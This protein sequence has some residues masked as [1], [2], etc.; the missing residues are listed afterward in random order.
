[1]IILI[2]TRNSYTIFFVGPWKRKNL[3]EM[4]IVTQ[5][6]S[7]NKIN[8][9]YLTNVLLKINTKVCKIIKLWIGV[10]SVASIY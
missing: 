1:M 8:D 6:I 9:Q 10:Y 4:G 7:P 2:I 5:C 3:V